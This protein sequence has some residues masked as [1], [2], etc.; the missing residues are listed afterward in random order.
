M[1]S[2]IL[3]NCG[4][5]RTFRPFASQVRSYKREV[6]SDDLNKDTFYNKFDKYKTG[7]INGKDLYYPKYGASIYDDK[8]VFDNN[9][10]K[11]EFDVENEKWIN[12][13]ED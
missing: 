6:T 2:L 13:R 3:K 11:H 5:H 9:V 10:I 12:D 1:F 4:F 7:E 8:I